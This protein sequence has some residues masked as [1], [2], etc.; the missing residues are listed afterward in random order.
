[1]QTDLTISQAIETLYSVLPQLETETVPLLEASGRVLAADLTSLVNHPNTDDS[2][3]DGFAVH[4]ESTLNAT[5]T[6][7]VRLRLVGE[8]AAGA[9]AYTDV[10]QPQQAVK[11]FTGG[12]VPKGAT[13]IAAVEHT[14]RDGDD[15]LLLHPAQP[16]IRHTGQDLETGRVYLQ[17]GTRLNGAQLALAA[18]MG[19]AKIPVFKRP[20]VAILPTGDEIYEPG[21]PLPEGAVY[22]AGSYGLYAKLLE[23]GAEPVLLPK[24]EDNL[25]SLHKAM[26]E[27]SGADLLLTIGGVSMGERDFVRKLL[28]TEGK[29]IFWRIKVKPGGPPMLGMLHDLPVFGLPGNPVSSLVIFDVVVRAALLRRMGCPDTLTTVRAQAS[30]PFKGAGA[31]LGLWRANLTWTGEHYGVAAFS[32]QSS[33][34]LRSLV[35]SNALA[36]VPPHETRAVG[37]WLEVWLLPN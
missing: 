12:A 24:V 15:V 9:K 23:L 29:P 3:L 31:K 34:V 28:E 21:E 2:A 32:N 25:K 5:P 1:M 10:L 16:E 4:L 17:E 7:P 11:V 30:T 19:H 27:A 22:N 35:Q 37:D 14:A 33:Q 20:K 8:V 13:G 6:N 36:L 18:A 26:L